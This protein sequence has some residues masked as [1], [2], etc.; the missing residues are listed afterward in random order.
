[1]SHSEFCLIFATYFAI[2]SNIEF[3]GIR[4]QL[5]KWFYKTGLFKWFLNTV[6]EQARKGKSLSFMDE[7]VVP[8]FSESIW[9]MVLEIPAFVK[10]SYAEFEFRLSPL[11]LNYY[12]DVTCS[13]SP[14]FSQIVFISLRSI[15]SKERRPNCQKFSL[16]SL[17]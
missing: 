11:F 2:L 16:R 4:V 1:M 7:M 17:A 8:I 13:A 5:P 12:C 9:K 10:L 14:R 3:G 6:I 15:P